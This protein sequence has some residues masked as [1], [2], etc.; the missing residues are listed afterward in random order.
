MDTYQK[1]QEKGRERP[2]K[3]LLMSL[4]LFI[5]LAPIQAQTP[6]ILSPLNI[7]AIERQ[8]EAE[9]PEAEKEWFRERD[10]NT[11]DAY[12]REY[13]RDTFRVNRV[14]CLLLEDWFE[15]FEPMGRDSGFWDQPEELLLPLVQG[16]DAIADDIRQE[17]ARRYDLLIDKYLHLILMPGYQYHHEDGNWRLL[18][19][20][21]QDSWLTYRQL[22]LD[23]RNQFWLR[24][25][26]QLW[27][28]ELN[29]NRLYELYRI[30]QDI[31]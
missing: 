9:I 23:L 24:T 13:S 31:M 14:A 19:Q 8:V 30:Y 5:A 22:M 26:T 28:I 15:A 18:M 16:S 6:D 2:V 27:L 4:L 20:Q 1:H 11:I 17:T 29:K 21:S 3:A 10:P 25:E 7:Q 12:E